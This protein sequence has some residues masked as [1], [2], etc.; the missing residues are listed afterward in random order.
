[1][2]EKDDEEDKG[3]VEEDGRRR[4]KVSKNSKGG[5]TEEE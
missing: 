3:V 4:A 5:K 2:S 1:M